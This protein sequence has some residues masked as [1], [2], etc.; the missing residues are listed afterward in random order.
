MRNKDDR[1]VLFVD[2]EPA[3]LEGLRLALRKEPY[4]IETAT[5]ASEGLQ[6]LHEK[7]VDVVVSDERM[8]KVSGSDFLAF[9]RQ[10]YPN[11][12]R[13][14]MTGHA[15]LDA[16]IL[17]INEGE[18]YRL[19]IKPC[20]PALIAQTLRDAFILLDLKR[21]GARLLA[22]TRRQRERIDELERLHPGIAR[23]ERDQGGRVLLEELGPEELIEAMRD[24]AA[25]LEG[26]A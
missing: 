24:E 8:P 2:D 1:T 23:V 17:A 18:V 25:R 21:E 16:A 7:P 10:R 11:T 26:A 9:I 19:L 20:S 12:F 5:S 6:I 13:I 14:L 3:L 22:A 4:R 15:S